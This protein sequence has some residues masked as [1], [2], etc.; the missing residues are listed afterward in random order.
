MARS[1]PATPGLKY[2]VAVEQPVRFGKYNLL[3][4]VSV[5]GMA[6]VFRAKTADG[7]LYAL[8]RILPSLAEDE[9]F[10]KMFIQEAKISGQLVHPNIARIFELGRCE[11]AHFI[12][13]EYVWGRDLTQI[14]NRLK[15]LKQP[16]PLDLATLIMVKA[17]D[18]MDY[19]HKRRDGFQRTLD[20]VHR[21]C[22]PHNML[23]GYDGEVKLIDFGIAKAKSSFVKT[24]GVLK[25]KFAY[26]SPEQTTG[27][28]IDRRS[29]IFSLG[30]VLYEIITGERLF[31]GDSDFAVLERVRT[32]DVR[33][34][35][36]VAPE[37]PPEIEAVIMKSLSRDVSDRYQW[38]S[39]MRADLA[40]CGI[41]T[42]EELSAWMRE[43]FADEIANERED[44]G[45]PLAG[46]HQLRRSAPIPAEPT[47]EPTPMP[48]PPPAPPAMPGPM[49]A[50]TPLPPQMPPPLDMN[51]F[52]EPAPHVD[53]LDFDDDANTALHEAYHPPGEPPLELTDSEPFDL[54]EPPEPPNEDHLP[55]WQRT[56]KPN[57]R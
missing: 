33:P 20:L 5:G 46:S 9:G 39:E 8:K 53:M 45:L 10:I 54:V 43:L 12:A 32:V 3:D 13:M 48:A 38:C 37:T 36:E 1:E 23:V 11:G 24:V 6:E 18:G 31:V 44:I 34:P 50:P 47:R 25:G 52:D 57:R 17:L 56:P 21:D 26:M 2:D 19:A 16:M 14:R 40:R 22:S 35:H 42:S 15:K 27:K 55:P 30:I 41:A 4:R 49:P 29:D 51:A 7:K 28:A